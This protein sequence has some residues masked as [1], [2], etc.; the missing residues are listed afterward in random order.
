VGFQLGF[1]KFFQA[2]K[3]DDTSVINKYHYKWNDV[4]LSAGSVYTLP[5]EYTKPC[6]HYEEVTPGFG[7]Y[8]SKKCSQCGNQQTLLPQKKKKYLPEFYHSYLPFDELDEFAKEQLRWI[9]IQKKNKALKEECQRR[10]NF[11]VQAL[12]THLAGKQNIHPKRG[13]CDPYLRDIRNLAH[14]CLKE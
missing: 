6:S 12:H 7:G 1:Y 13:T 11:F 5:P 2:F 4:I 14:L 8:D 10:I 3:L 9:Q